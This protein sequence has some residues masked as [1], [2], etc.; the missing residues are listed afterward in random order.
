MKLG[1][2]N[3]RFAAYTRKAITALLPNTAYANFQCMLCYSMSN[4]FPGMTPRIKEIFLELLTYLSC[5]HQNDRNSKHVYSPI[6][7][8]LCGSV[9]PYPRTIL[10]KFGIKILETKNVIQKRKVEARGSYITSII[11]MKVVVSITEKRISFKMG[12]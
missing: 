4:C 7:T 8:K 5:L 2:T 12:L 1:I 9:L 11:S 10:A 3:Y 6:G